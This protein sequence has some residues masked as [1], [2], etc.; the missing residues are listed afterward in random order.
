MYVACPYPIEFRCK[1]KLGL[2][3]CQRAVYPQLTRSATFLWLSL[4]SYHLPWEAELRMRGP[5]TCWREGVW[6]EQGKGP[7]CQ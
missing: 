5:G 7:K 4:A 2:W 1:T 3:P 6:K